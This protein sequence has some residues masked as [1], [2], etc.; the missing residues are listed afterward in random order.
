MMATDPVTKVEE[1]VLLVDQESDRAE[2]ESIKFLQ[3]KVGQ[4]EEQVTSLEEKHSA[5]I[6]MMLESAKNKEDQMN[7]ENRTIEKSVDE[8]KK[9]LIKLEEEHS[10][11]LK[12]TMETVED[13]MAGVEKTANNISLDITAI[14]KSIGC[15][16]SNN[17]S[18][19]TKV[20]NS[21]S[22]IVQ[23]MR[24]VAELKRVLLVLRDFVLKP[25]SDT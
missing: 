11:R 21:E 4:L 12:T 16:Q 1:I 10:V 22:K 24:E 7:E 2:S 14:E 9:K 17:K 3:Q 23:A 5:K 25:K 8:L 6:A 13:K 15:M 20:A 18:E 19:Q